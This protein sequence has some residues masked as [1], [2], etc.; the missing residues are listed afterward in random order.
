MGPGEYV[1]DVTQGIT[2][3]SQL[4]KP[5]IEHR[6]R[7]YRR[8]CCPK[9]GKSCYRDTK[10][11]RKIHDLGSVRSGR[12]RDIYIEYSK[13]RCEKCDIYFNADMS[14][15]AQ[16]AARYT[17]RVVDRAVRAVVED[18][19]SYNSASWRMWSDHRV[20]VP[21]GTVQNWV[22]AAGEKSSRKRR[23]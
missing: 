2:H 6:S 13:H 17:N 12:P 3:P 8:R 5:T 18:G 20:F 16:P 14:D 1:A 21:W 4:P 23:A 19:L 9:C 7:M 22:E 15:L 11:Q 10:G